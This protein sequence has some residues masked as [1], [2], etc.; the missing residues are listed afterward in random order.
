[1]LKGIAAEGA[2]DIPVDRTLWTYLPLGAA[3]TAQ[4]AATTAS[5]APLSQDLTRWKTGL[6]MMDLP[7]GALADTPPEELMRWYVGWTRE[8]AAIRR[9]IDGATGAFEHGNPRAAELERQWEVIQE[10]W[11]TRFGTAGVPPLMN[12]AGAAACQPADVFATLTATPKAINH[13]SSAQRT[14]QL[15]VAGP[16]GGWGGTLLRMLAI[17]GLLLAV[18]TLWLVNRHRPMGGFLLAYPRLVGVLVGLVWWLCLTPSFLG[19]MIV[20]VSLIPSVRRFAVVSSEPDTTR[21][22]TF[23]ILNGSRR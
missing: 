23:P 14:T 13:L 18:V 5:V 1:V 22:G 6:N 3:P 8:Q 16:T 4:P 10:E 2:R 11:A 15:P 19:W 17:F 20:A 12:D 9:D 21:T 7:T